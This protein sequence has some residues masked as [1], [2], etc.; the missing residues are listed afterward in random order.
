M[1][2][3]VVML[4]ERRDSFIT[5]THIFIYIYKYIFEIGQGNGDLA[6]VIRS[7]DRRGGGLESE[8]HQKF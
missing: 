5:E 2:G 3:S 8:S 4:L 6:H 7:Y 1:V